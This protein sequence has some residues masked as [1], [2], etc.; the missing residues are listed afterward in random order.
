VL[1]FFFLCRS[2][3]INFSNK[4]P[5]ALTYDLMFI[6][7][8]YNA[9]HIILAFEIFFDILLFENFSF[10][11][12]VFSILYSFENFSFVITVF[13]RFQFSNF[14][15]LEILFFDVIAFDIFFSR[16]FFRS[17][18]IIPYQYHQTLT[19]FVGVRICVVQL[20]DWFLWYWQLIQ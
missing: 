11:T 2:I 17:L 19:I 20:R 3:V 10:L 16:L 7:I 1:P 4:I 8:S 5:S 14:Y 6:S 9:D 12:L 15:F 18:V 13:S